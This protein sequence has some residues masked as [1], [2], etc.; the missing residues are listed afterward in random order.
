MQWYDVDEKLL[1]EKHYY[2]LGYDTIRYG[3]VD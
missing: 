2:N 3:T 1:A